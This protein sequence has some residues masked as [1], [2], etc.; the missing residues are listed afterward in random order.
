MKQKW[1]NTDTFVYIS[2]AIGFFAMMVGN[3]IYH[4]G[5]FIW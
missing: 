3:F 1:Y 2:T 4:G 5:R